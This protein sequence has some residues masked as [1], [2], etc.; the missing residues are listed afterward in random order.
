M[1]LIKDIIK[2]DNRIDFGKFQTF[3]ETEAVVPDKKSDVY[4]IIKTEGYISLK[5][6]ELTEG[7]VLCRGS[8]NYNVIKQQFQM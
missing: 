2:V 3:I 7:K 8:F 5:K 4:E 6:V 1:E